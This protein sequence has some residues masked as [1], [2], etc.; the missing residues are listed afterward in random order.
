MS[1]PSNPTQAEILAARD[2]EVAEMWEDHEQTAESFYRDYYGDRLPV[3]VA[4][5]L[6]NDPVADW[7]EDRA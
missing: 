5:F 3:A 6:R 2:L 1:N 7:C 4:R